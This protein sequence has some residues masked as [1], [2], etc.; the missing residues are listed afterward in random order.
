MIDKRLYYK[1]FLMLF[2]NDVGGQEKDNSLIYILTWATSHLT[3]APDSEMG[4]KYFINKKCLLQNCFLTNNQS[5]FNDIRQ[6]DVILF[7]AVTVH[8]PYIALPFARLESQKYIFMS[9]EPSV[10]YPIPSHYNGFFNYTFTYLLHSDSTW[11]FF[12]VKDKEGKVI[13]PKLNV[14]WID[15]DDI[16]INDEIKL[17]LENKSKAA[18]WFVSHCETPSQREVY[19][20]KLK[21][22]LDNYELTI[23]TFGDCGSL[24]CTNEQCPVLVETDYFFYL[25]FEN[26]MCKDYV[27]EKVL[28]PTK[29]FAVPI[30][31]GGANYSRYD[32]T[33]R[34]HFVPKR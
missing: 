34:I 4:Q 30:V 5:Y 26:S 2:L 13:A 27:T 16:P 14:N 29:H 23:D 21:R 32:M 17:K 28:V 25:V 1:I 11:R 19:V 18:A 10:L 20:T 6:F 12:I 3:P 9:N 8:E 7:H 31:Y 15:Y 33:K 24:Q 22:E